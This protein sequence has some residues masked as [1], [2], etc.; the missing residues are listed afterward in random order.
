MINFFF[1]NGNKLDNK[2]K[3]TIGEIGINSGYNIIVIDN[4][5]IM[6]S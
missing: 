3:R 6:G 4:K 1:I 5:N 2:E